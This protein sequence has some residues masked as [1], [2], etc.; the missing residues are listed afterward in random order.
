MI[1]STRAH[2]ARTSSPC[3]SPGQNPSGLI[4]PF[5][6]FHPV[7]N[8]PCVNNYSGEIVNPV[9]RDPDKNI[10]GTYDIRVN[11]PFDNAILFVKKKSSI[12]SRNFLPG[13]LQV[14]RYK[15]PP[16][17]NTSWSFIEV[18]LFISWSI[19]QHGSLKKKKMSLNIL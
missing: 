13:N 18:F 2:C 15:S 14:F 1:V 16:I 19:K 3:V 6:I 9:L 5:T 10:P 4:S 17:L 7:F 12:I 11:I 8:L